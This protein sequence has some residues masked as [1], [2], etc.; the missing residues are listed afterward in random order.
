MNATVEKYVTTNEQCFPKIQPP[1]Q[2]AARRPALGQDIC[3][4]RYAED[5][6]APDAGLYNG[7]IDEL[8]TCVCLRLGAL[9]RSRT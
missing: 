9:G 5:R 8:E 4:Q 6:G 1:V 2:V 7:V 3:R